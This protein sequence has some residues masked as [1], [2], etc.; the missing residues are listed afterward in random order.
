M[1]KQQT[2]E[3]EVINEIAQVGDI[4]VIEDIE[5]TPSPMDEIESMLSEIEEEIKTTPNKTPSDKPK[6]SKKSTEPKQ[7]RDPNLIT[8]KMLA[9]IYTQGDQKLVRRHL[10]KIFKYSHDLKQRWEWQPNDP[11]LDEIKAYFGS[12]FCCKMIEQ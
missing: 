4:E 6:K 12:K 5:I 2:Q 3:P 11:T 1:K 7:E 9:E 10:R 8:P